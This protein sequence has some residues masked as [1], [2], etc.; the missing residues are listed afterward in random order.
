MRV[1]DIEQ[2]ESSGKDNAEVAVAAEVIL[3]VFEVIRRITS[4][5]FVGFAVHDLVVCF[6]VPVVAAGVPVDHITHRSEC[7]HDD[8][9]FPV[10]PVVKLSGS[11]AERR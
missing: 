7:T 1:H 3:H 8:R 9:Y 6:A 4:F 11:G 10:T 5:E 2:V